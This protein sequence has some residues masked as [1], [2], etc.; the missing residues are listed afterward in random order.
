M[1]IVDD[2]FT[3]GQIAATNAI[4][5]VFAMGGTPLTA[6]A[7]L[8]L[9]LKKLGIEV[10]QQIMAGG[11]KACADAGIHITGGHSIDDTEPKFGLAVT[12]T[13]HPNEIMRN[14]SAKS[15]DAL[16]L[17]KPLGVG[18]LAHGVKQG[19]LCNG[20]YAAAVRSMVASNK[21]AAKAAMSVGVHGCTD[22][23]GF[24]LL[25]HAYEMA[26]GAGL[27]ATLFTTR[28]PAIPQS[29]PLLSAGKV[30]GATRRNLSH[31]ESFT[32]WSRATTNS[33]KMLLADPQTSGGLLIAVSQ[34]KLPE[35]LD[36][37]AAEGTLSAAHVGN[38]STGSGVNVIS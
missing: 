30:P 23:T 1:P 35:L 31:G 3:F 36:A 33:D 20:G 38:M 25:G 21:G 13:V 24:G 5:D 8:G 19:T 34:S 28:L 9:P 22:V 11:A 14:D 37:L 29:I 15:G 7:I 17:T 12:G 32:T 16:V 10:A 2:P 26:R 18:V 27:S 6:L 4:S